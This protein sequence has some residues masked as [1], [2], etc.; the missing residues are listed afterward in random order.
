MRY[1]TLWLALLAG[2]ALADDLPVSGDVDWS[3]FRRNCSDAMQTLEQLKSPLPAATAKQLTALL[4]THPADPA[5]QAIEVQKLLDPHCL[6]LISINPE[7]RVKA[8]RGPRPATLPLNRAGG[9][10]VKIDNEGG[11][12]HPLRLTG[13]Q[14]IGGGEKTAHRWLDATVVQKA[15]SQKHLNGQH[16][17]YLVLRLVA[18]QAG[19]REA[20]LK[21]N[22]GQGTQDLG[23]RAEVPILFNVSRASEELQPPRSGG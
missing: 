18:H 10:L 19:K 9:V 2:P 6:V 14:I 1:A 12:T 7:S 15:R 20:L 17:Q 16:V 21:F 22:V 13:P 23:F 5:K 4:R 11:V 3:L 8:V